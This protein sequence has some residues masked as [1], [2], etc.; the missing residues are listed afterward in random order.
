MFPCYCLYIYIYI[1]FFFFLPVGWRFFGF[2]LV[3]FGGLEFRFFGRLAEQS[4][5]R[6]LSVGG[7]DH[8]TQ[9]LQ[10]SSFWGAT[11]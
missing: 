11:L 10:S 8:P 1:Y 4:T 2:F 3:C 5:S 6:R 7:T 9:R